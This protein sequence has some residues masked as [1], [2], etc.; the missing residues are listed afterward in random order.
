MKKYN[1]ISFSLILFFVIH[2]ISCAEIPEPDYTYSDYGFDGISSTNITR[3]LNGVFLQL[4]FEY[5]SYGHNANVFLKYSTSRTGVENGIQRSCGT[6]GS[7]G[8]SVSLTN[9]EP[10]KTYYYKWIVTYGS[11]EIH[12]DI[13]S[14]K[15][16]SLPT[17][18]TYTVNG[19]SFTM[20]RVEGGTFTMGATSEQGLNSFNNESPTH[21]V[22]LSNYAIGETEVTQQLWYAVMGA[23]P[24]SSDYQWSSS[25]GLGNSYPAYYISW[26]D[27]QQFITKLNQ[28]TGKT[29]RL[30]TEAEWEYA[31]RGGSKSDGYKYSGSN[32]L[33]YVAWYDDNSS[34]MAH[35]VGG[36]SANEL[37]I[38][39]MSGNLYEWCSDWYGSYSS[40][41]QTN[42]TGPSTGSSRVYRGGSWDGD[43]GFCRV[44]IHDGIAPFYRSCYCGMRLCLSL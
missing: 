23:K 41:S 35:P 32:T 12:S 14:F 16:Y 8:I 9:L 27:C 29:F 44:S 17:T 22:T 7:S 11:N 37:G 39:D 20:V 28:L 24:T 34:G 4:N 40:Y 10:D 42:P 5:T 19:V 25:Y 18:T 13:K 2:L 1:K 36:K 43:A 33:S 31:A 15:T 26:D 21:Q 3:G 38:Y 30:P 6:P